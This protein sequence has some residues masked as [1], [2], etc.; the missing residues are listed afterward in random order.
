LLRS[1]FGRRL[2]LL[3][4]VCSLL[5]MTALAILSFG[6]VTRQL[7]AG[8]I[9]RLEHTDRALASVIGERL[10]FLDGDM[11]LV[12]DASP[13]PVGADD[14]GGPACD[15]SLNYAL[16]ALTFVPD[17]G[18]PVA[19]FGK[20]PKVPTLEAAQRNQL[21]DGQT[22]ITA[23][24]I[25]SQPAA[26]V[27]R[28]LSSRGTRGMLVGVVYGEYLWGTPEENPLIPTM[29]L[30]IVDRSGQVLFR[31]IE[32]DVELPAAVVKGLATTRAGTFEWHIA[33]VPYLAA[34]APIAAP[35][36]V[37]DPSWV[38]VLSEG[39]AAAV[40][41][42]AQFRKT[43]PWVALASLGAALL[44]TLALL[45]RH[46]AP[47]HAL[48]DGTRRL[49]NQQF[50]KPVEVS[51]RDEFAELAESFNAMA[52]KI[53]R[54]FKA[55]EAAAETDQA[56]LSSVDT[57]RIVATVLDRMRDLCACDLVGVT[58]LDSSTGGQATTYLADPGDPTAPRAFV[59]RIRHDDATRLVRRPRG[60]TL[61]NEAVPPYLAP[62]ASA[63]EKG[64]RVLPLIYQGELLGAISLGA[65]RSAGQ[66]EQELKQAERVAG[67]V[68]LA[69][70]NAR[71]VDQIRF[72]AYFDSL[73]G[74]PNRVSFKRR[75]IE[76]LE[77][78]NLRK[79]RLAV[80]FLDLDHFSRINDTL[81]HRFGDRLVQ[82]VAHRVRSCC[83]KHAPAAEVAR[84]GGDE[85]TV[86]VPDLPAGDSASYLAT[87][88]LESFNTP[89]ALD[90]HEVFVSASI[91][92]AVFPTDGI[93]LESLLKNADLAMYQAKKNGRNTFNLFATSME[94]SANRRLTLERE[95]RRAIELEEFTLW[96]QP[97]IDLKSG[98]VASAEALVRWQHPTD[99]L[100]LPAEFIPLCEETGFI[101]VL[102]EWILRTACNQNRSWELDGLAAIPIAINLSGQQ[103]RGGGTVELVRQVLADSGLDPRRLVLELTESTLMEGVGDA[104]TV[105][106]AL[107]ALGVGLAIDD[108]GTGY[109][110]LSYLKNFPVNALK[111]DKS[112]IRDVTN[113]P[114]DAAITS[115][116]VAMGHALELT[117]VAEG[118]ETEAQLDM[119]RGL[120]CDMIQG[121]WVSRP[122]TAD[123]F[124]AYLLR[125]RSAGGRTHARAQA[126]PR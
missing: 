122:V 62:L 59:V 100:I 7:R 105:L 25:D 60:F 2:L 97:V 66:D 56:V 85:F 54:Q 55:L 77:Q 47:L 92:I 36:G 33:D 72:L 39:R 113:D 86:I 90:G 38:L 73:T 50:D 116:I 95:L 120:G 99:G 89:F 28:R 46:L 20:P 82:E 107:S 108:F 65:F 61:R 14:R 126:V 18:T 112:F 41:P 103:L 91:G 43:F 118:V 111:I 48:Q 44:L 117:V 98:R 101:N 79:Q 49:A 80:C 5:P 9:G 76:D 13:C 35:D 1:R 88:L 53:A 51:S 121:H 22:V 32:G 109:S 10:H 42:M 81:G 119:L 75:L 125:Q 87:K 93:D 26:Y 30:H 106:P 8:S 67:Q 94:T 74:L 11:A 58:L 12:T 123:D 96:Y 4:L 68:V 29:Q 24:V 102:G 40:A 34:Y 45:R 63:V 21:D 110:S 15:G 31:S 69:L 27:V 115:A 71:M 83:Q 124:A 78:S 52:D 104:R 3:F 70:A 84:L 64:L 114:N 6:T 17:A 16:I 19:L 37:A 57:P 23:G